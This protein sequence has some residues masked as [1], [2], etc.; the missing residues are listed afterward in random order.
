MLKF[1]ETIERLLSLETQCLHMRKSDI[2][3]QDAG[4]VIAFAKRNTYLDTQSPLALRILNS[5]DDRATLII[6]EKP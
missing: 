6:D 2:L 1:L 4:I 3:L 5:H